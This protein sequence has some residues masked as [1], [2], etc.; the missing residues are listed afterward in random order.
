MWADTAYRSKRSEVHPEKNEFVSKSTA[1]SPRASPCPRPCARPISPHA[2]SAPRL[3]TSSATRNTAQTYACAPSPVPP[4]RSALR[5]RQVHRGKPKGKP[6]PETVRKTNIATCK[7]RSQVAH[8][9]HNQKHRTDLCVC[10]ITRATIKIGLA[11]LPSPP[12]EAQ[13]QVHARDRAQDQHRHM[14]GPLP[15]CTHLPQP[16]TPHRPM[17]VHHHPCHHQDRPCESA[18]ST[19]GSPR[20][21]PCPRP[22][23]RPTSP[24]ARSAPRLHTSSATRNTAWTVRTITRATTK[25][26]LANPPSPPREAQGQ[27]HARDRAQDQRRHMQGPLPS[28]THLPRPETPHRPMRVH[29]HPCHHQDRPCESA[30]STAG[31]PRASPCPRPCARPTSPHARS[32][33]RLHTSSATRNTAQTYAC[34]PSPAPPPRSALRIRQVHRGKPKGKPMPE[35]VRKTNVATCKVCSQVAHIFRNQKH[36]TDLCVC[37]ITRAT[38]KIGLANPVHHMQGFLRL[39]ARSAHASPKITGRRSFKSRKSE[40]LSQD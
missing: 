31:S 14:Q 27:A 9:F 40:S 23:A 4:P 2:R 20:A 29:H 26:G 36:R 22:C 3:H 10:T 7:V 17:R 25:I 16:E 15:G 1:G 28:C 11:N 35:T 33:P 21:S 19:A 13:G 30:K 37:T 24:H 8:I 39:E 38:T 12:R 18:K 32:A 6:M 5:I 34:A